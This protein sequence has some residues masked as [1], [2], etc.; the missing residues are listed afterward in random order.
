MLLAY[1]HSLKD[2]TIWFVWSRGLWHGFTMQ[3][4]NFTGCSIRVDT[5]GNFEGKSR[6]PRHNWG[7]LEILPRDKSILSRHNWL[8]RY[9]G[10]IFEANFRNP[11]K[12]T[13][14]EFWI[15]LHPVLK[16]SS[17]IWETLDSSFIELRYWKWSYARQVALILGIITRYVTTLKDAFN[18]TL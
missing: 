5:L 2:W 10:Q 4:T 11:R 16:F 8:F 1:F 18:L 13:K 6:L 14:A 12:I 3:S 7:T 17:L 9:L 15:M